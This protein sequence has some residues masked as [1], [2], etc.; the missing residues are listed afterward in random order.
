LTPTPTQKSIQSIALR[1]TK[2]TTPEELLS[3]LE[4]LL[5]TCSEI[6]AAVL[7][8]RPSNPSSIAGASSDFPPQHHD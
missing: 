5:S 1:A 6:V 2:A 4:D 7:V 3:V 8:E